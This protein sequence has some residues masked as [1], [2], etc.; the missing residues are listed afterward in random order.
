MD[1]DLT[2]ELNSDLKAV[3]V[4]PNGSMT[5]EQPANGR[6]QQIPAA[7]IILTLTLSYSFAHSLQVLLPPCHLRPRSLPL[8]SPL[9]RPPPQHPLRS[10][11]PRRHQ[12]NKTFSLYVYRN[13]FA[14]DIGHSETNKEIYGVLSLV[15]WTLSLVPLVKYVFIVLKA[16]DNGEGSTFAN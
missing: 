4:A 3:V 15:F 13:T 10:L 2:C 7:I 5:A 9:R 11:H 8:P 16:N 12:E 6:L 14:E 1:G